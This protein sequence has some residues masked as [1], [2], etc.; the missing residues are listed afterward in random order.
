[1]RSLLVYPTHAN[2]REEVEAY[3]SEGVEAVAYPPRIT[4]E[5]DG[6]PP[7][8]WNEH[9]D[10]AEAFGFPVV[11][12]VC[13]RCLHQ[14]QCYQQGYLGELILAKQAM[15]ALA[16]HQRVAQNGFDDLVQDRSYLSLHEA[17]VELLRPLCVLSEQDLLVAQQLVAWLLGDPKW[18]DW[19]ADDRVKGLDGKWEHSP[20]EQLRRERLYDACSLLADFL[21]DLANAVAAATTTCRWTTAVMTK[22]PKGIEWLLYRTSRQQRRR[23]VGNPWRLILQGLA[24]K[25]ET[26]VIQASQRFVKGS[27]PGTTMTFRRVLGV[28][29]NSPPSGRIVWFNDATLA[30]DRLQSLVGGPVIDAT[31]DGTVP[32]QKRAVQVLRDVT[33][34]TT[35]KTLAALL[36]SLLLNRPDR[37]RLGLIT[38]RPLLGAIGLLE[39]E[40]QERIA[41]SSYFGS[42]EERSSNAWHQE[43]D[44]IVVAGTPRLPPEGIAEYLVQVRE[45]EAA[46]RLPEWGPVI[47]HGT[48]ESSVDV[49]VE[50]KGYH[51]EVWRSAQR[52]LVRAALVQAIGRGRGILESGCDVLVL[53]TEECGLPVADTALHPLRE[54]EYQ[55]LVGLRGL[56]LGFLKRA[57]LRNASV[58][59]RAIADALGLSEQR[60]RALLA[61]LERRGQ[62]TRDSPRSGWKIAEPAAMEVCHAS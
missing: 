43:C 29:N 61:A 60:T 51:D 27:E 49:R 16:T 59:T 34:K 21:D 46:C 7:N 55:V 20:E 12:T 48:T 56:T 37:T 41:R 10:R 11:K 4:I 39:P 30:A 24:G 36:R 28:R 13:C 62:V 33:R 2:I 53:S 40:F 50:A 31:P 26:I 6:Q 5:T 54:P 17:P 23:Y 8:C 15:I 45:V 57:P 9:A 58:S 44:L 3:R 52:D 22:L 32:L 42:G 18:L 47:W 14:Q 38:H 19:F 25:L 35:P 1:M